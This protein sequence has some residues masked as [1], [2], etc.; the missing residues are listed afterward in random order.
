MVVTDGEI[1]RIEVCS[2]WFTIDVH[3]MTTSTA[4]LHGGHDPTLRCVS[5]RRELSTFIGL[6][7][8]AKMYKRHFEYAIKTPHKD[9]RQQQTTFSEHGCDE[10]P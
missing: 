7:L 3:E 10:A 9:A 1:Y 5:L 2:S 6:M 8:T 4:H